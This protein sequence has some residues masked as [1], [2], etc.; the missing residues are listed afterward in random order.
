MAGTRKLFDEKRSN[1]P[2][3]HAVNEALDDADIAQ[4]KLFDKYFGKSVA[5]L[6]EPM[7]KVTAEPPKA[8]S[9]RGRTMSMSELPKSAVRTMR[10]V[11]K[12]MRED[13]HYSNPDR[14]ISP[15][16]D[17]NVYRQEFLT[18]VHQASDFEDLTK[19]LETYIAREQDR[20]FYETNDLMA[21]RIKHDYF[22]SFMD[23]L[24]QHLRAEGQ[25]D[26]ERFYRLEDLEAIYALG[27]KAYNHTNLCIYHI[28][29]S[30]TDS[31][32]SLAEERKEAK[33]ATAGTSDKQSKHPKTLKDFAHEQMHSIMQGTYGLSTTH[34]APSPLLIMLYDRSEQL[35]RSDMERMYPHMN[36]RN[37]PLQSNE[38]LR[39][40][41]I[42]IVYSWEERIK[43]RVSP[44]AMYDIYRDL[45][46]RLRVNDPLPEDFSRLIQEALKAA[47]TE[48]S[49]HM[50]ALFK[51][52]HMMKPIPGPRGQRFVDELLPEFDTLG[53]MKETFEDFVD[54]MRTTTSCED[55]SQLVEKIDQEIDGLNDAVAFEGEHPAALLAAK[56]FIATFRKHLGAALHDGKIYN[57]RFLVALKELEEKVDMA[58]ENQRVIADWYMGMTGGGYDNPWI[59]GYFRGGYSYSVSKD[60]VDEIIDD[61]LQAIEE[62]AQLRGIPAS[63]CD[64]RYIPLVYA[65]CQDIAESELGGAVNEPMA[66]YNTAEI[67][68]QRNPN[69]LTE[70]DSVRLDHS[71]VERV[72]QT[73]HAN[74]KSGGKK[75]PWAQYD[76]SETYNVEEARLQRC[77]T[78]RTQELFQEAMCCLLPEAPQKEMIA[79][80]Q[81]QK[82]AARAAEEKADAATSGAAPTGQEPAEATASAQEVA[83]TDPFEEHPVR[84]TAH[85]LRVVMEYLDHVERERSPKSL[86]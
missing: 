56:E 69:A 20:L 16:D 42:E 39:D 11:N 64:L 17:V 49:S 38:D 28:N 35:A 65:R 3:L 78:D 1:D 19:R 73:E 45:T 51:S 72:T 63:L 57:E 36:F 2:F 14:L 74:P 60:N 4:V 44:Q 7:V 18:L 41:Y 50:G 75:N 13:V 33:E 32:L 80:I 12:M 55:M 62:A 79:Q 84:L 70:S 52:Y 43:G 9:E 26:E 53:A 54:N 66:R 71:W 10:L 86:H 59:G 5:E 67:L 48:T 68:K 40:R 29:N 81:K 21:A 25:I 37:C 46:K 76:G 22:R 82:A 30:P 6:G 31:L 61:G 24:Y 8:P 23:A 58:S 27:L 83:N 85:N 47:E 15:R 34:S 77:I